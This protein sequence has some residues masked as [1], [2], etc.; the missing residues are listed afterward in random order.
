M[1]KNQDATIWEELTD[2]CQNCNIQHNL[3]ATDGR[4]L[5]EP[6]HLRILAEKLVTWICGKCNFFNSRQ[7]SSFK[8]FDK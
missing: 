6:K 8:E 4:H 1:T 3:I 5:S 7:R 2:T